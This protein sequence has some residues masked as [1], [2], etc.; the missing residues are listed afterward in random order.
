MHFG[1]Y[2]WPDLWGV[3]EQGEFAMTAKFIWVIGCAQKGGES[4]R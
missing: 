2:D 3:G 4:W 1:S